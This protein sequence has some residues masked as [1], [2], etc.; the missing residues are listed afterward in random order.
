MSV[1][2]YGGKVTVPFV[3]RSPKEPPAPDRMTLWLQSHALVSAK[4]VNTRVP[5][6][7]VRPTCASEIRVGEERGK[8]KF[9]MPSANLRLS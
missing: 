6:A 1:P 5:A 8:G 2:Y 9:S 7:A 4:T 3:G